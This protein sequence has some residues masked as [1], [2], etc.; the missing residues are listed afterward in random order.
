MELFNFNILKIDLRLINTIENTKRILEDNGIESDMLDIQVLFSL[1]S[2]YDILY[3]DRRTF[4]IFAF[5]YKRD[6]KINLTSEFEKMLRDFE[7]IKFV[8]RE[9]TS[10][11]LEF[12]LDS[13]LEKISLKGIDSLTKKEREFLDS[14][15]E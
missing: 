11:E 7:S 4:N 14:Q 10:G 13:I 15:S 12:R 2:N 3:L 9:K 8:K 1:K 5:S 6:S